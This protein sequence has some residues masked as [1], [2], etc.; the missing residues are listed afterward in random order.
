[1]HKTL[2]KYCSVF[3]FG[4]IFLFASVI[5]IQ[6]QFV[7]NG[8][9][10]GTGGSCYQITANTTGQAG[11]VF[12]A[13]TIDLSQPFNI[14]ASLSFGCND[15]GADGIVFV[16]T[17]SNTALGGTGGSI[18]YEVIT[19]SFA[20]EMDTWQNGDRS[21]P[22]E[23]HIAIISNG[24]C[25][26]ALASNLAGP[27][28]T[29]NLEDCED[30][31]FFASWDP[32]SQSFSA[33]LDGNAIAYA[34]D[35]AA[36]AG[37]SNVY[38]GF[39]A[40]TGGATNLQTVCFGTPEVQPMDDVT[41]CPG[42]S[43]TLE[44]DPNGIS[45]NW[46]PDPTLDPWNVQNPTA[47]PTQ[48]TTYTVNIEFPCNN[49]GMDEVTVFVQDPPPAIASSNSPIC[50]GDDLNLFANGGISY[51]WSGPVGFSSPNQNPAIPNVDFTNAGPY[52]VTVTDAFG[53][54]GSAT[55]DVIV[56]PNPVVVIVPLPFPICED[57]DPVQ[58]EGVP[59][60]GVWGGIV[61]ANGI[62]DPTLHA[63][64]EYT[65]TY[66]Y[67]DGNGCTNEAQ[68]TIEIAP[69]PE[70]EIFQ[71]GPFCDTD[72][73]QQLGAD[74]PGGVW[75]GAATIEGKFD[76]QALGPGSHLVTYNYIDVNFCTNDATAI[77][78]V[79]SGT[80]VTIDSVGPFCES[81]TLQT[82]TASPAGGI[83]GGVANTNGEINPNALGPGIHLVTYSITPMG[84]CAGVDS[85]EVEVF[86]TPTA[87]ISGM[88][89]ICAGSGENVLLTITA[90]GEA[91]FEITYLI[92]DTDTTSITIS[93]D[94]TSIPVTQP[95]TYTIL[96]VIDANGCL[97]TGSG[98]GIVEVV[99]A[100]QVTNFDTFCDSTQTNY[101]VTFEITGGD[102]STY[103]VSGSVPG[104]LEP[105]APYIFTSQPIPSGTP[106]SFTVMDGN[107]CDSITL[108][109]NFACQCLTDAGTM[110][111]TPITVCE[112][113][114]ITATHNQD[115]VLDA[116]DNF[117]FVIHS[118]NAN[119][120][121]TVFATSGTP[122]FSLIPPM[123][124]GV[125][126]YI[127][128]VAGDSDGM[129]GI[130]LND[131]CLSVSFGTPV[132][133]QQLPS[134][135]ITDDAT[136]CAGE[137]VNI[138]FTLSGN[139]P[140]DV[141]Y[142]NGTQTFDLQNIFSGHSIT[143]SPTN[144]TTYELTSVSDNSNPA[145]AMN[146]SSSVTVTVNQHA[147]TPLSWQ[148]C[149]GDSLLLAG[150]MQTTSGIYQDTLATAQGCDS[151]IVS[152]LTVIQED[153][154]FLT[155]SSCNPANL[156]TFT[157]NL[158]DQNGCD[159][160]V[161]L[162][163]V[164][165][166]TDTFSI[167]SPTC[168]PTEVGVFTN[169]YTTVDGCDSTVIETFFLLPSDTIPISNASCDPAAVGI[170]T[171][172]LTNQWGCDS[173]VIETVS[174]LQSDT[175]ELDDTSC[176]PNNVGVFTSNLTNQF[177]CDSLVILTVLFSEADTT[178]LQSGSCDP[179]D[180][181]IFTDVLTNSEGCDSLVIET[182]SLLQSDS[183]FLT[184]TTCDPNAAGSFMTVLTNQFGCDSTIFLTVDLLPSDTIFLAETTCE[185]GDTGV[186]LVIL[187]NQFGC[188]STVITTTTLLPANQCFIEANLTGST[189]PCG[190][191]TGT[192]TTEVTLGLGPFNYA[193]S[194]PSSG[195]S[196]I[197]DVNLSE[198]LADL[199]PGN[200]SVT[201]TGANGLTIT[202][203]A[204]IDQLFP[205]EAS[206][207]ITSSY[208]SFD[209]SCAGEMDGSASAGATGGQQPYTYLWSNNATTQ[210][211]SGLAA[212]SYTIT[213][214]DANS[215]TD[216]ATV[217]LVAPPALDI[218]FTVADIDCFG[219]NEGFISVD[220]SGGDAPYLFSING[221]TPQQDNNFF[222][223]D[224]GA[225]AITV[226]DANGCSETEIIL[227]NAPLPVDV[228]LTA[229]EVEIDLSDQTTLNALISVPIA[230]L[231]SLIWT[232][233]D[234]TEC[235][236]CPTQVIAPII[237]TTYSVSVIADNGCN[238]SDELTIF[239]DRRKHVYVPNAFS[240]DGNGTNDVFMIFA[241]ENTVANI[242]SFLVFDRWGESVFEY[243][244]FLPNN[245]DFGWDGKYRGEIM[246]P[247]VFAW[248]AEIEFIDGEVKLYEGDVTI[249]K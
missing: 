71:A 66:T 116:N 24:S 39:T 40:S 158:L 13:A 205:P 124:P 20:V 173:I 117:Y 72:P 52:T 16:L 93:S 235:P 60:G 134:G 9:A 50:E 85:L 119:S 183:T 204:T 83:W 237:T 64:G 19:P 241:K 105:N 77:I 120:L 142:S 65:I 49:F 92:D 228:E 178:L 98:A 86:Q 23:D 165:S 2:P 199:P 81:E 220:V 206:A 156:G 69:L 109:G 130:D 33:V 238:D 46:V 48:T 207:I 6:A 162:T 110:N 219:Q 246:N 18:A 230:T 218:V 76:P 149:E 179:A 245:P 233:L 42:E 200:Y 243:Y 123:L 68:T 239:V 1:M 182:V 140:F 27:I 138:V 232:G 159:S 229:N 62:V 88:G 189:I 87:T 45:W 47:T 15:G 210:D 35:I 187:Q 161:V 32:A 97:G 185:P 153:T 4:V 36:I 216:E 141:S 217:T 22:A 112:D 118:G 14:S 129:G 176:D 21:D 148:I 242:R 101:T 194:G 82:L 175:T 126:Y 55:V 70:V 38:Y 73:V 11:S 3:L 236:G 155:D 43:V 139:G 208:N 136:I 122:T 137:S 128:A 74:P 213:V 25:D 190:E 5:N 75:G 166:D 222:G 67:T 192:L 195:L 8:T 147:S 226:E 61:N 99:N 221:S 95:G 100:P 125:T 54:T 113:L 146:L 106:Y 114:S 103:T 30:H 209:I 31:C 224:A 231:D 7:T 10:F 41:I 102:P 174:L 12:S 28:T 198:T 84:G 212:G 167:N 214:T 203:T 115:S 157:S 132:Q 177:G 151:V 197:P 57:A 131:P 225:Y 202:L 234:S 17:T 211:L 94:S 111:L 104:M 53:C 215:C 56:F 127:S 135:T 201:V 58:M 223:L 144:T 163:V 89:S 143:V 145:C 168:D 188:D 29:G 90:S 164:F 44:A 34:G 180:V 170:F 154:T 108:S 150:E 186:V 80:V 184:D 133:W 26:H 152:T 240:P 169:T 78:E 51:E 248:F 37:S 191:I 172:N 227:I 79:L 63:P 59:V 181:G 196:V 107:M 244:N 96:S 160:V 91:P 249:V 121:G 247:Q 171:Y 193:W